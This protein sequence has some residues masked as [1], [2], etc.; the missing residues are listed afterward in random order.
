MSKYFYNNQTPIY[1]T[2]DLKKSITLD[3]SN[4][5]LIIQNTNIPKTIIINSEE[6]SNGTQTLPYTQMYEN[7]NAVDA[8]VY[9]PTS[10][11]VLTVNNEINIT[12][13]TQTSTFNNNSINLS[14]TAVPIPLSI[15]IQADTTPLIKPQFVITDNTTYACGIEIG[16]DLNGVFSAN[17]SSGEVAYFEPN[18]FTMRNNPIASSATTDI[19]ITN[20]NITIQDLN[21]P[22][23]RSWLAD[24]GSLTINDGSSSTSYIDAGTATFTATGSGQFISASPYIITFNNGVVS[25]AIG[26][27]G[28][29]QLLVQATSSGIV[30]DS[31][32][33]NTLIGDT[34]NSS[35]KTQIIVNDTHREIDLNATDILSNAGSGTYVMPI[36]FTN[37]FSSSYDYNSGGSWQ[38]VRDNKMNLPNE[39]LTV[40]GGYN[41]W[42]MDFALNCYNMTTQSDKAYAMYVV[43]LDNVG[44]PFQTWL[45]NNNTPY[46]TYKNS[47]SYGNTSSQIENFVYTDYVDFSGATGSPIT[48]QLWRFGD[49]NCQTDFNWLLT[50]SKTNLV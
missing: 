44:N 13:G 34:S 33:S 17:F 41:V 8:C 48:I 9:P 16:S 28:A 1:R 29:N 4:N 5:Q 38:M 14:S 6:F 22:T 2:S 3:T 40:T 42:K 30:L 49:N 37:K 24:A 18:K 7:I 19:E 46:T 32:A 36:Q 43:F 11:N 12:N 26:L 50:L 23:N 10:S 27:N 35:N 25:P 39:L 47:S 21:Q 15:I 31:G 45:F 20:S